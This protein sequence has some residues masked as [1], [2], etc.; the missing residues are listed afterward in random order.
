[1]GA[2]IGGKLKWVVC[3]VVP[4]T[5]FVNDIKADLHDANTVY[6]VLDNHKFGDLNPY[7]LKSADKGKSWISIKGD[8][9]EK[10]L[11]WRIVQDHINKNL[12]FAATEFG[13]YFTINTGQNWIKLIGN[14]PTISFRDL[15]IQ[16][17][18]NDLVG[19]SFGRSFFVLDDYSALR[20]VSQEQLEQEASLFSTRKAWW[21]I[22][23]PVI[24]FDKNGSQGANHYIAPNPPFGACIYLLSQR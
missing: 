18:E 14:V 23:R 24:G 13:I 4:E 22:E 17:R 8:I 15:A 21:Y 7:V 6:V 20:S 5:A 2:P 19:A 3:Q 9:P 1:M 12:F 10:T 16:R 11:V